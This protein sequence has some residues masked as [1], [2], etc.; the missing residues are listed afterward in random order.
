MYRMQ[1]IIRNNSNDINS[2]VHDLASWTAEMTLK[3]KAGQHKNAVT[4]QG[5]LPPIRNKI[6]ISQSIKTAQK[7]MPNVPELEKF[8]RDNTAMPDYYKAWDKFG[9]ALDELDEDEVEAATNPTAITV[10]QPKNA[11][12]MMAR[13]SGAAPNTSIVIKGGLRKP[14]SVAEEFKQQ[15]NSYFISLEYS[16]AIDCYNKCLKAIDD[17]GGDLE[18]KK[19]VLSN[20]AQAYIKLKV[21]AKAFEDA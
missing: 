11:A 8:K 3:E 19:L 12:E 4:K 13:T 17:F 20:R 9:K 7:T 5:Q 1:E 15:G 6:D 2:A 10:P 16:K 21:Y 14:V 18:I